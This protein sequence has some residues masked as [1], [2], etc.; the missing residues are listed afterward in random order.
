MFAPH[1]AFL[2]W[3]F[4]STK[5]EARRKPRRQNGQA[6]VMDCPSELQLFGHRMTVRADDDEILRFAR[7]LQNSALT[8][9]CGVWV[10]KKWEK[11]T[12]ITP[13]H[14]HTLHTLHTAGQSRVS[15]RD[16]PTT[17]PM[18]VRAQLPTPRSIAPVEPESGPFDDDGN[19]NHPSRY[20]DN[21]GGGMRGVV[22]GA[23][24]RNG[25]DAEDKW[26]HEFRRQAME[27][28]GYVYPGDA[29]ENTAVTEQRSVPRTLPPDPTFDPNWSKVRLLLAFP[30][31]I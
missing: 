19:R 16:G 1:A 22:T 13:T 2:S 7:S 8:A 31:T 12:T 9:L 28:R 21:G 27:G 26:E 25:R 18:V 24:P 4:F 15:R 30:V 17:I 23:Q 5:T 3:I 6:A 11:N 10:G 29:A 14:T 20:N